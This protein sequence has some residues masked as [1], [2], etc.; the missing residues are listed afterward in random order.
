MTP[1]TAAG[2]LVLRGEARRI[3]SLLLSSLW[4]PDDLISLFGET[5][6]SGSR[7]KQ[8]AT[9]R[10]IARGD[11]RGVARG[12]GDGTALRFLA[13]PRADSRSIHAGARSPSPGT[14]PGI[15]FRRAAFARIA[16]PSGAFRTPALRLLLL[17]CALSFSRWCLSGLSDSRCPLSDCSRGSP[18]SQ[19]DS[20]LSGLAHSGSRHCV[21]AFTRRRPRPGSR[22]APLLKPAGRSPVSSFPCCR[23][24]VSGTRPASRIPLVLFAVLA[25]PSVPFPVWGT[26][27]PRAGAGS[28][29]PVCRIRA[30]LGLKGRRRESNP[31]PSVPQSVALTTQP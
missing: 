27:T 21:R 16:L 10:R 22:F 1:K 4:R 8:S 17:P 28:R 7:A 20:V 25:F 29:T 24:R 9:V 15:A 31:R 5:R 23:I 11:G 13:R 3:R 6:L 26:T 19:S 14:P 30:G 12:A 2:A 18:P